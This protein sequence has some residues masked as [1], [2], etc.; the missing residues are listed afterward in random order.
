MN[1]RTSVLVI[2]QTKQWKYIQ[3][4]NHTVTLIWW[5]LDIFHE[6]DRLSLTELCFL[7][8]WRWT[9]LMLEHYLICIQNDCMTWAAK[10]KYVIDEYGSNLSNLD[11]K[12]TATWMNRLSS[13]WILPNQGNLWLAIIQLKLECW[14]CCACC[15]W[16]VFCLTF[17]N[18]KFNYEYEDHVHFAASGLI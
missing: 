1:L 9:K 7:R 17:H 11:V 10:P 16:T 8:L 5:T 18:I 13:T 3:M 15:G 6:G 2:W 12:L 14:H 4:K